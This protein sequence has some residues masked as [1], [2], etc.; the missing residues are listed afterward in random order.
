[1]KRDSFTRIQAYIVDV[2]SPSVNII[3]ERSIH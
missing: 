2:F 3:F 1:M